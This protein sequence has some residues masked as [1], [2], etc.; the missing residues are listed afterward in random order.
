MTVGLVITAVVLCVAGF[1]LWFFVGGGDDVLAGVEDPALP[2]AYEP[3]AEPYSGEGVFQPTDGF[4]LCTAFSHQG[5]ETVLPVTRADSVGGAPGDHQCNMHLSNSGDGV[6]DYS[7][8]GDIWMRASVLGSAE[9]AADAFNASL[10][11][12]AA[13]DP[14]PH[15]AMA[16]DS[17]VLFYD[18]R[19]GKTAW[20]EAYSGNLLV[21]AQFNINRPYLN[22][23]PPEVPDEVLGDVLADITNEAMTALAGA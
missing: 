22:H 5:I 8:Q 21:Q 3:L 12:R 16:V 23:G 6:G 1:G 15:A 9:D 19:N 11:G 14:Q 2:Q 17:F 18:E 4:D 20:L 7:S 10:E 13:S